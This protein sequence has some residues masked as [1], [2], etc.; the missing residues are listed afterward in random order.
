MYFKIIVTYL[1][2]QVHNY[3]QI[4]ICAHVISKYY[5]QKNKYHCDILT[6]SLVV[7]YKHTVTKQ[8]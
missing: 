5:K 1:L 3:I 2:I 8:K 4:I 7:H 6:N